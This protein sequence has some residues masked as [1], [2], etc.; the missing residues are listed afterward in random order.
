MARGEPLPHNDAMTSLGLSIA[1]GDYDRTRA[2]LDGSIPI[3]GVQPTFL[4]LEPEEMFFRALRH[5][6]FDVCELSMSSYCAQVARGVCGYIAVPV[7]LSRAFRHTAFYVRSDSDIESIEGLRGKRVGV[8]E[9]QLT[10]CVWARIIMSDGGVEPEDV[11]WV[12]AGIEQSGRP[13]KTRLDLPKAVRLEDAGE[14]KTLSS[15][16]VSG[17]IDAVVSPRAP[18]CFAEGE[19]AVRWLFRDPAAAARDYYA[20]TRIFPIMHLLAI[21]REVYERNRWVPS[22]LLKAFT[23]AKD[24]AIRRLDDNAALKVTLPF[25]EHDVARARLQMG[26]DFWPYGIGPN[27]EQLDLFLAEHHRQGLSAR[28]LAPEELFA[29]EALEL[30]AV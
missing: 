28:R 9:Y 13:E 17:E 8:P 19:P 11:T 21:R 2:L 10:A 6:E 29:E 14:G 24:G 23:L 27:R 12:R 18:S 26:A 20:R 3:D 15:M 30:Y 16:L 5:A 4:A 22:S 25:L 1:I 7:F